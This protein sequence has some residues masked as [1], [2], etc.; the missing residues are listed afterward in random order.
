M[1]KEEKV[2]E[3]GVAGA[4]GMGYQVP[5]GIKQRKKKVDEAMALDPE[6]SPGILLTYF[7]GM[8]DGMSESACKM[9][10]EGNYVAFAEAAKEA[11]VREM[12]RNKMK[13]VVRKKAGGGGYVLYS[14]NQGKK[15]AAK[16][17]GNFPTKLGAKK[18]ELSRFPPKDPGK[19]KRLRKE[20]DRLLK[21]PKKRAE[22]EK[23][24]SKEKGTD[25]GHKE[26]P[27]K[28]PP[29]SKKESIAITVTPN[30]REIAADGPEGIALL[31]AA[32]GMLVNESLFH[33][34]KTGS[35]WDE[36]ITRLSK[37]ALSSDK[38]FQS[39]QKNIDKKTEKVLKD[40]LG[41]I[42]KAVGKKVK[43]KEM[44]G[45]KV[46]GDKGKTYLP[47]SATVGQVAVEPIA[48]YIEHGVPKIELSDQ[49][50]TA[51]TKC[52][53]GESKLFRAELIQVQE[54]ILD[55]MDELER[56]V[57]NRDRYLEKQE[58]GVDEMVA[59][60]TPLQISLLKQVLVKKYRKIS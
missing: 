3:M 42:S 31:Q 29:K 41:A 9:L 46:A 28:A 18:A 10:D 27:K 2:D 37:Q 34:E 55:R 20:V 16:P 8:T 50:K 36:Y 54:R 17:V 25:S 39:L 45:V 12:V 33:E 51:L 21:D 32:I 49:A 14:P 60:L 48:L 59:G 35:N 26:A 4:G 23:T 53:P 30:A 19:L 1:S 52:D 56:A 6:L 11:A 22:K 58:D 47:F 5:M 15:K 24:A 57:M 43:I 13:E 38:K 7:N 44:G 40:A